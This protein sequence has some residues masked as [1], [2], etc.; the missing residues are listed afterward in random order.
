MSA[1]RFFMT[2]MTTREL[3]M[4]TAAV[5]REAL[6]GRKAALYSRTLTDPDIAACMA[7]IAKGHAQ[8]CAVLL[9]AA[10]GRND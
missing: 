6:L 8:R 7:N 10:G 5:T 1:G 3:D 9:K 2:E 4:L